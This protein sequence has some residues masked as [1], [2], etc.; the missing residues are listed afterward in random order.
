MNIAGT[1]LL[2]EVSSITAR[3]PLHPDLLEGVN[4][5]PELLIQSRL[6]NISGHSV[7]LGNTPWRCCG[8]VIN[9]THTNAIVSQDSGESPSAVL[10]TPHCTFF[11]SSAHLPNVSHGLEAYTQSC[12]RLHDTIAHLSL[13]C[14]ALLGHD[15][16]VQLKPG[17]SAA[18]GV[19]TAV[20]ASPRALILH[21]LAQALHLK[22]ANTFSVCVRIRVS[23]LTSLGMVLLLVRLISFV[24]APESLSHEPCYAAH[25]PGCEHRS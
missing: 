12:V 14:K 18:V 25:L 24:L 22:F 1:L 23:W 9:R 6:L 2:Q 10:S 13:N 21:A 8:V 16:N 5:N 11:F 17:M 19:V 7:L 4:V 15:A 20:D 3:G